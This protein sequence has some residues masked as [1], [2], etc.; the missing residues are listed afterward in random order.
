MLEKLYNLIEERAGREEAKSVLE[1]L[2]EY[3]QDDCVQNK[4]LEA[5]SDSKF[6]GFCEGVR[7]VL[8][9]LQ[10]VS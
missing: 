3:A 9:L 5:V 1:F 7:T 8:R 10:E 2:A 6:I 4:F